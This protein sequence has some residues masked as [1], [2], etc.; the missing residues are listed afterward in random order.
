MA[1]RRLPVVL[2]ST[3]VRLGLG[4]AVLFAASSL[5]L[6]GFLWWLTA[7]YLDLQADTVIAVDSREIA[8]QLRDFGLP[9]AIAA[10]HERVAESP[11]GRS[12][13][14]LADRQLKP[15]AGNLPSW[16]PAVGTKP[17]SYQIEM[18]RNG[19]LRTIR[20]LRVALPDGLNLLVGRDVEDRAE[21]R[22]LVVDGLFWAGGTALLLGIGGGILVRRAVL[23]RVEMINDTANA[24]VRGDLTQRIPTRETA[25]AFDQLALTI[26]RMLQQIDQL[27]EGVRNTVNAVAHD[28]RTPLAELRARLEDLL[29]T[30]PARE[31]TFDEIH[32]A[33]SDIDRVIAVFN[34]LLRLAEIDSGA[35]RSGFRRVEL[36]DLVTEIAELYAPLIEEKDA[37]LAVDAQSGLAIKGDPYLLAQA[38]GNLVDN[39]AKYTRRGGQV[40]LRIADCGDGRIEITVADNGPGIADA[41]K[42]RVTERF[43]R[44]GTSCATAGIGLGL[45]LVEAVARLHDGTLNLGDGDP[46]LIAT[47]TLPAAPAQDGFLRASQ[48]ALLGEHTIGMAQA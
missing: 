19:Q 21:L 29:R 4:Y 38:V 42:P 31:A 14:L 43:Y 9:G 41:D 46:G 26:N 23:A 33:V 5:F 40:S 18:L 13:Y 45:S 39:A 25:D 2:R 10:I 28:L 6:V 3:S 48:T 22:A 30:R 24:I 32:K 11:D 36:A 7:G 34:A 37:I 47:L 16:P 35:R 44:C 27:V 15:L 1:L 12:I 17:S 8:D 20:L